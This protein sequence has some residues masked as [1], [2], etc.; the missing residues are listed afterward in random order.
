MCKTLVT[1]ETDY[2]KFLRNTGNPSTDEILTA[3]IRRIYLDSEYND[4][5][6]VNR[7]QL[8]L[9]QLEINAGKRSILKTMQKLHILHKRVRKPIGITKA[10]TE[11]QEKR[12]LAETRF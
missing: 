8:A 4:N 7:M 5:Y 2:Y 11:I 10:T 12:K 3:K 1:S 6:G 9:K